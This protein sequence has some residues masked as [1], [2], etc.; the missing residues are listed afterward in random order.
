MGVAGERDGLNS[1]SQF[2]PGDYF[3]IDDAKLGLFGLM[4]SVRVL[5]IRNIPALSVD[6]GVRRM[7]VHHRGQRRTKR[8]E[9]KKNL[10]VCQ[11]ETRL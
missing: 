8:S 6:K 10:D 9:V 4:S 1:R 7:L 11:V 2:S 3:A 5:G